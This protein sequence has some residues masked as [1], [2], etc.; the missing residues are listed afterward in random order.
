MDLD[1][2]PTLLHSDGT[3]HIVATRLG[4]QLVKGAKGGGKGKPKSMLLTA[5]LNVVFG[6]TQAILNNDI[7]PYS[8]V[9][10]N[11]AILSSI[12]QSSTVTITYDS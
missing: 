10:S 6:W 2:T 9:L 3:E 1:L 8:T 5:H 12:K 7:K 11:M 4:V